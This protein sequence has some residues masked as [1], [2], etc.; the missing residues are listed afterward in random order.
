MVKQ[1]LFATAVGTLAVAGAK[2]AP[3][4]NTNPA[5]VTF[6][7]PAT[8]S[9]PELQADCPWCWPYPNCFPGD[10]CGHCG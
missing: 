3:V 4:A 7:D 1:A 10:P 5:N 6:D 2:L 8:I 9:E